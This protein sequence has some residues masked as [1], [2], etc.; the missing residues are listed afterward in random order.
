VPNSASVQ[1]DVSLFASQLYASVQATEKQTIL[2]LVSSLVGLLG[3]LGAFAT[4]FKLVERV[5]KA[6]QWC[7]YKRPK[8]T[9]LTTIGIVC[10]TKLKREL[11]R[12]AG[13]ELGAELGAEQGADTTEAF[14]SVN[15]LRLVQMQE[16]VS[17]S[18]SVLSPLSPIQVRRN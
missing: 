10:D 6:T 15:P 3:I 5:G 12:E 2:Q 16:P 1:I 11:K 4:L 14:Q 13:R 9:P 17:S 7:S 18:L 8:K